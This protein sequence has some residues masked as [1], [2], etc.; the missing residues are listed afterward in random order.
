[1]GFLFQK[2]ILRKTVDVNGMRDGA[3]CLKDTAVESG[4]ASGEPKQEKTTTLS[5]GHL[6]WIKPNV[7][8][9]AIGAGPDQFHLIVTAG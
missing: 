7:R 4:C 2:V 5:G 1:M 8:G 6:E 9:S 3:S